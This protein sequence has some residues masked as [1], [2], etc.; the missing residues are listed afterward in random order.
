MGL[1]QA[2]FTIFELLV[3]I[4]IMGTL[5]TIAYPAFSRVYSRI[6]MAFEIDDIRR[7]MSQLPYEVRQSG[8]DGILDAQS[9][10][11]LLSEDAAATEQSR[12]LRIILPNG[13]RMSI[14]TPIRYHFSGA[15]D[16][17]EVTFTLPP[18]SIHYQLAPP[19]CRPIAV[20]HGR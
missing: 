9:G 5:L 15:C 11:T 16:G 17:G 7:Q 18:S 2:G 14:P 1:G 4:V 6:R 12:R 8:A 3:V 19:L 20:S 10:E 13:W